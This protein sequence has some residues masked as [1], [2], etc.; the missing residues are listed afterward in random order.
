MCGAKRLEFDLYFANVGNGRIR[1]VERPVGG[2]RD[3]PSDRTNSDD[4]P[5]RDPSV[6]GIAKRSV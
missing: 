3:C 5:R 1:A 6:D 2:G 4:H